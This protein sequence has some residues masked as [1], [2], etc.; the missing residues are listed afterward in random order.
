MYPN[1]LHIVKQNFSIYRSFIWSLKISLGRATKQYN[2]LIFDL[3]LL[4]CVF[5]QINFLNFYKN[6]DYLLL[7]QY[8]LLDTYTL[9]KQK[10]ILKC[11]TFIKVF[12]YSHD[13]QYVLELNTVKFSIVRWHKS[14]H[15]SFTGSFKTS[16]L[17]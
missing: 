13:I 5:K 9:H 3:L 12:I 10:T 7:Y 8:K 17:D 2:Y 4:N 1:K 16:L 14:I 15:G 11:L 6:V